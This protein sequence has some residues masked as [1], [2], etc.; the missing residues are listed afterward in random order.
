MRALN[1]VAKLARDPSRCTF[2][3]VPGGI[4]S[5]LNTP[6]AVAKMVLKPFAKTPFGMWD[7]GE[8]RIRTERS[9]A[10]IKIGHR[11]ITFRL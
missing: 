2:P 8:A 1:R 4:G 6:A 3:K 10:L 7:R 5:G 9:M 11:L